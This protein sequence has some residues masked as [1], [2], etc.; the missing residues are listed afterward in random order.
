MRRFR[1]IPYRLDIEIISPKEKAQIVQTVDISR[2]GLCFTSRV[3]FETDSRLQMKTKLL[4]QRPSFCF[5]GRVAWIRNI[6]WL[7]KAGDKHYRI[8][9]EFINLTKKNKSG[10]LSFFKF[11]SRQDKRRAKSPY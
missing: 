2:G 5:N 9:L 10:L 11:I 8:G 4:T 6:D 7:S 3:P 1:R